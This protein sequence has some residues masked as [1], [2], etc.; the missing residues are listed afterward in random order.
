[1]NGYF[2][3]NTL[4]NAYNKSLCIFTYQEVRLI[5]QMYLGCYES[6]MRHSHPPVK[7]EKLIEILNDIDYDGMFDPYV[8]GDLIERY[9]LTDYPNCDRNICHFFSG[10]IRELKFYET[11]Y[12]KYGDDEELF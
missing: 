3:E 6:V 12:F 4:I 7:T 9:F 2:S 1:M 11:S 8:Y 5:F 10:K